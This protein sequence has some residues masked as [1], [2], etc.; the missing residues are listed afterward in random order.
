MTPW[1]RLQESTERIFARK[2]EVPE[3][4]QLHIL[5]SMF[6]AGWLKNGRRTIVLTQ[7][8]YD[9]LLGMRE[10]EVLVDPV[11]AEILALP[12]LDRIEGREGDTF[13][14]ILSDGL[15]CALWCHPPGWQPTPLVQELIGGGGKWAAVLNTPEGSVPDK[16]L[17]AS[18]LFVAAKAVE[19]YLNPEVGIVRKTARAALSR[20]GKRQASPRRG[21]TRVSMETLILVPERTAT[22]RLVTVSSPSE[23][24]TTERTPPRA[25]T[26]KAHTTL[27][28]VLCPLPGEEVVDKKVSRTILIDEEE[29]HTYLYAVRRERR[30]H[31]RG[32]GEVDYGPRLSLIQ[33]GK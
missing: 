11:T 10:V 2:E 27:K 23:G 25:H 6:V 4:Q 29:H 5:A 19:A 30:G 18:H 12:F 26:V 9:Q 14:V 24:S 32:R 20:K 22:L 33:G 8:T 31:K 17:K 3:R 15:S 1:S 28:W 7:K 13:E 21:S 16:H